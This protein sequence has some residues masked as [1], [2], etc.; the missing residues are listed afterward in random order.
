MKKIEIRTADGICPAYDVGTGPSALLLIDGVGMRPA[1]LE[2]ALRLSLGGYRVL[3]PDLFYRLGQYAPN[4]PEKMFADPEL[5]NAWW[6]RIDGVLTPPLFLRD[7]EAYLAELAG[8]VGVTGYCMGGR[9]ALIA[10]ATF[11]DR[12]VAAAAYHPGNVATDAPDSPHRLAKNIKAS[13]YIGAASEDPTFTPEQQQLLTTAFDAAH[14]KY[15]LE[16]YPAKH[17]WVPTDTPVHDAAAAEKHWQTLG[18]LFG[19][20]LR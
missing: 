6:K 9:L 4:D 7:T 15:Q 12:I 8:P 16:V 13:V 1:M 3:M 11:S 14:V 19:T 5:R 18:A 10:A 20:A 17:G 2:M